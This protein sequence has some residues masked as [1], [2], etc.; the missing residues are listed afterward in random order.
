MQHFWPFGP[1]KS[2]GPVCQVE[3]LQFSWDQ[4]VQRKDSAA[5]TE[6][7]PQTLGWSR[8]Q[9]PLSSGHLTDSPKK[10][11]KTQNCPNGGG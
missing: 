1:G 4:K 2:S 9:Q 7:Y 3:K 10:V 6:L 8:H 5:V 11:T